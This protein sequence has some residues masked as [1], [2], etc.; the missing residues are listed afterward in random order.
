MNNR[1]NL[2]FLIIFKIIFSSFVQSI[3]AQ[4]EEPTTEDGREREEEEQEQQR[5]GDF[6]SRFQIKE[7]KPTWEFLWSFG[8]LQEMHGYNNLDLRSLNTDSQLEI[9]YTDDQQLF[10]VTRAK[11][12]TLFLFPNQNLSVEIS[13]G[14]DGVW[15]HDQ[16]Q[17]YS[18]PGLRIGR[19]NFSWAF[20]NK[21]AANMELTIGRQYSSIGGQPV[22]YMQRDI[23]DAV[24][25]K[26]RFRGLLEAKFILVDLFSGA[27]NYGAGGE[28]TWNDEFQF[29]TRDENAILRGLNG[30]VSTYRWGAVFSFR[31][32]IPSK[33]LDP[34]VYGFFALIR[35]NDGGSDRSE[36]GQIGNFSD[37]DWSALGGARISYSPPSLA[38]LENFIVYADAAYS[39]GRDLKREGE[40]E[41]R[42]GAV[43]A[44][45]GIES[46]IDTGS[47]GVKPFFGVGAFWAQGPEYD[48]NGNLVRHSFV[49][50]KGNEVGGLLGKRYL[51][52]H[53][54][55]YTDDDGIDD[56]PFD[57]NKKSGIL[58]AH[59]ELGLNFLKNYT[60][61]AGYWFWWDQGSS[62]VNFD[63]IP[64][65]AS[66]NQFVSEPELRAQKKL[67]RIIGQEINLG[68]TYQPIEL[69]KFNL[70]LAYF[71]PG[72]F[73]NEPVEEVVSANGFPKGNTADANFYGFVLGAELS[74]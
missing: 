48:E 4:E 39:F 21:P 69:L 40:P 51:G 70:T 34:R 64:N 47:P 10:A 62:N 50:F 28:K 61:K 8:M 16:L 58:A 12:D 29:L 68:F 24:I 36:N 74:F 30:D 55:A 14:F 2:T 17:G 18:N 5:F 66:A 67:G 26:T 23:L 42:I 65:V 15:G 44:G 41:A 11:F 60:I 3:E 35:G 54:S 38:I 19:A 37:N 20:L 33:E 49:S 43:G 32:L 45:G 57:A 31:E 9:K 59:V 6:G 71:I 1:I 53:P 13:L 22:D 56:Q 73:F 72:P 27:N 63:D 7:E 25:L 46:E 52:I